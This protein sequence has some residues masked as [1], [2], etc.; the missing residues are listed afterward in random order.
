MS[1][2]FPTLRWSELIHVP[3]FPFC[4]VGGKQSINTWIRGYIFCMHGF[5]NFFNTMQ[6]S[7]YS[8]GVVPFR[9]HVRFGVFDSIA[10]NRRTIRAFRFAAGSLPRPGSFQFVSMGLWGPLVASS[11]LWVP[12]SPPPLPTGLSSVHLST[13]KPGKYLHIYK[14][15]YIYIIWVLVAARELILQPSLFLDVFSF[16]DS[17]IYPN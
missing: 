11:N 6:G 1:T 13:V 4:D 17:A 3:F 16:L 5:G 2:L 12:P 7:H 9:A 14:Y 15:I 10:L 8:F